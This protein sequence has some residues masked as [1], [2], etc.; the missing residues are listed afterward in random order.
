MRA[1]QDRIDR[2]LEGYTVL[3]LAIHGDAA[4]A[5]Q[6]VV[7]ETLNLSQL[8]GYRTGGTVHVIVNNQVGFTTAP[9]Y[10]RSSLYCTDVAR[11]IQAP[12]FHVNGDDPEAVVRVARLAFEY[13]H[14]V[15]QGRRHRH[16]LLPPPRP[17]RGRRPVDDQPGDVPDHRRQALGPQALH[18]G[19][20]RP[21]RHLAG[22]SP[23]SRCATSSS[24]WRRCSRRPGTRPTAVRDRPATAR[25]SRSRWSRTAIAAAL[26]KRIGDAHVDLPAGLHRRTSASQ[27]L[28]ERRAKMAVD[29]D[30][31]WGFGEIIAFGSLLAQGVDRAAVRPGLAPRHVRPAARRDRGR[32]ERRRLPAD[33]PRSP[34]R[35]PG[36][37]STTRCCRSTRRWASSTATRWRTPRRW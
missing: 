6:G 23:R 12:I 11:M 16:G 37:S 18:R 33:R 19:A 27:Q 15:Q 13:R 29:G 20:D 22:R 10:S 7:A 17:Q 8:R 4:F 25:S 30:I 24:S 34:A 36:S 1:K 14:G 32:R 28:L 21:R 2:G 31:D 3:A 26:V 35:R 9:E 5:G